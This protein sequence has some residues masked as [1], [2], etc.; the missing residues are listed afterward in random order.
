MRVLMIGGLVPWHPEAGGGQVIAF[1][2]AQAIARAGHQVDYVARAPRPLQRQV[3][4]GKIAYIPEGVRL[5]RSASQVLQSLCD[6]NAKAYD[7][8][9]VHASNDTLAQY[10]GYAIR[11]VTFSALTLAL[12]IYTP[13]AY[14]LP[15]SP[16]EIGWM[17]T[18]FVADRVFLLSNFSRRNITQ[19][20]HIPLSKTSVMYGGVAPSFFVPP[21]EARETGTKKLLFCGRLAGHLEGR[22]QQKG[23]DVLLRALPAILAHHRVELEIVGGGPLLEG[24]QSMARALQV[25]DHVRFVG[26][27]EYGRMPERYANADLFILPSRHESFSLVLAEAMAAGLPVVATRVGAI[28]EVVE[29]GRTGILVPPGDPLALARAVNDLLSRPRRMEAMGARGRKRVESLFTW[30]KVAGRVLESYRRMLDR[31]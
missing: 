22:R 4:W 20:Y 19:A 13:Q 16:H 9:H 21:R 11:R 5:S 10:L 17:C 31:R 1:E 8:V 29:D 26:F 2:L 6:S 3:D 25:D 15:R 27:M 12:G 14:R 30:D 23:V 28:P 7:I 24:F 18:S